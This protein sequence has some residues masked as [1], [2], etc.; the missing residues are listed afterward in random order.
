MAQ[1]QFDENGREIVFWDCCEEAE[2]LNHENMDE[3]IEAD[4]ENIL[5]HAEKKELLSKPLT[6]YGFAR[7]LVDMPTAKGVVL[8]IIE[9]LDDEYGAGDDYTEPTA[10][11]IN[12]SE[13]FLKVMAKEYVSFACEI[14]KEV[15]IDPMEWITTHK[16]E[17]LDKKVNDD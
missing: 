5:F 15:Q 8:D 1:K 17:W 2:T 6:V 3:A 14:V 12:A 4:I 9:S 7:M 10:K 13:E 16:P 11:M